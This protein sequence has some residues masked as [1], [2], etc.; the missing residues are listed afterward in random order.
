MEFEETAHYDQIASAHNI[1]I[2]ESTGFAYSVG[3]SSGGETCGGGLHM[4]DIRDPRNPMFAGC[5]S[6]TETGI[7]GTGY[8][9]DALCIEYHGPDSEHAGREICFGSNE[10]ALSI[11]DVTEKESPIK[12]SSASY[13]NVGYAHQGWVTEDHRYFYMDDEGDEFQNEWSGTRT[14]IW[15]ITDLDDPVLVKEHFGETF[16]SDHNLYIKGDYVYQSNYVSGLRILDISDPENPKEV[17]FFD[18]VPWSEEPGFDGSWSNYPFFESGTIVVA[19]MKEGVFFL[20]KRQPE[21][22][23]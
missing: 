11:A 6:D 18:T 15:D 23:P 12:L 14:L 10:N 4:I 8:S 17:G 13:P 22:V 19:S 5:F 1:V 16:T 20:K 2:N 21:L 3:T 7:R 9:H